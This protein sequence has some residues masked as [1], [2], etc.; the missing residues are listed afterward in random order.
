MANF[1]VAAMGE[2]KPE[3]M[4]NY[5]FKVLCDFGS[6]RKADFQLNIITLRAL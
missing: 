6:S 3:S 2:K 4:Q 1:R 5:K